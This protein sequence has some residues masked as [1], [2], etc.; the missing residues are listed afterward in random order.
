MPDYPP[1]LN[2]MRLF[3][4]TSAKGNPYLIGRWGGLKVAILKSAD[5]AD[6]GSPIWKMVLSEAAQRESTPRTES[7]ASASRDYQRHRPCAA[8]K[9]EPE[10]SAAPD[11]DDA[12][13][14]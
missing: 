2:A 1:S 6:D 7:Q 3:E 11:F 10:P 14:F 5:T 13:P 9:S 4:K 8:G 12:I